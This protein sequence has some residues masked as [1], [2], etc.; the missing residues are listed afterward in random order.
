ML[1]TFITIFYIK[2]LLTNF[3]IN[4][5]IK[6]KFADASD[7]NLLSNDHYHVLIGKGNHI[8]IIVGIELHMPEN[9]KNTIILTS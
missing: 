4:N 2:K 5:L 1:I 3:V 9:E 8:T 6:Q 7:S